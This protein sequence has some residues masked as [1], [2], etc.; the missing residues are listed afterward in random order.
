MKHKIL[1]GFNEKAELLHWSNAEKACQF[2]P[3]LANKIAAPFLT[4]A[5]IRAL[6]KWLVRDGSTLYLDINGAKLPYFLDDKEKSRM[7]VNA[8]FQDSFLV[9]AFYGDNHDKLIVERLDM[10]MGEGPYGYTDGAFDV[11]VKAG[12][13]V[14][15]AGAWI[16]DFSAYAASK[17]ALCYAFEPTADTFQWLRRTAALNSNRIVPVQKGLSDH[18]GSAMI[19]IL[20][21]NSGGN[22]I[23]A[24]RSEQC[25]SILLTTI[26]RFVQENNL[27]RVDF[28]KADIEGAERDMLRGAV[29]TMRRFAPKL[30]ICTYHLPDD[31]PV[32]ERIILEANPKY[33]IVHL[34]NKLMAAVV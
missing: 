21:V 11:S 27:P 19:S 15:D 2:L 13:V 30:A 3:L 33:R 20:D 8:I 25:E 34:R 23:V 5:R 26:D 29:D 18:E 14:I 7:F 28:I 12:D 10:V 4:R 16:G 17:G 22:S 1:S 32:L 31:K 24:E 9:P 6:K